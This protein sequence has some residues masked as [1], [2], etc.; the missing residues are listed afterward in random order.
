MDIPSLPLG[1]FGESAVHWITLHWAP[2]I[3]AFGAGVTSLNAGIVGLLSVL[4][5]LVSI[6]GFTVMSWSAAGRRLAL[7]IAL[8]LLLVWNQG[9][10]ISTMKTLGLVLTATILSLVVAIPLGIVMAESR[11]LRSVLTPALDFLQT[12]PRFVY[13]IPAVIILGLD[14][15]PA[16]F[17]TMT[18]AIVPPTRLTAV[19]IAAIERETIEAAESMGCSRWQLLAKVKL[20]LALPAIMLGVNQCMMMALSMVII[21]SLIGAAG[22]GDEILTAI[23][24][25]DPGRGVIA[26]FAVL[27]L[28]IMLDRMTKGWADKLPQNRRLVRGEG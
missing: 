5:P 24:L 25:L 4:P 6:A 1:R 12:M 20:P 8:G 28:A 15:A 2:A 26:G 7:F 23:A 22:L 27:V 19:G 3:T 16:V 18:L 13:L 14:V 17:A 21:A 10:W 9:L 11:A